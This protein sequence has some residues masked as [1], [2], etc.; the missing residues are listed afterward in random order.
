MDNNFKKMA[1][2]DTLFYLHI[3]PS[4]LHS[5]HETKQTSKGF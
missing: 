4:N 2:Y 1:K 3:F 5:I